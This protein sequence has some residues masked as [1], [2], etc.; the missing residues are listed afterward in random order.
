M[1][2]T[3]LLLAACSLVVLSA[4]AHAALT[5][6]ERAQ[7]RKDIRADARAQGALIGQRPSLKVR[8]T[9]NANGTTTASAST[10][11]LQPAWPS[12]QLVRRGVADATFSVTP[13][14]LTITPPPP[15]TVTRT[16]AWAFRM[17][18]LNNGGN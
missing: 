14:L 7:V 10:R 9:D 3:R 16:N 4:T 11:A 2:A 18:A 17:Y 15:P 5:K 8:F 6:A 1:N 12:F 13:S